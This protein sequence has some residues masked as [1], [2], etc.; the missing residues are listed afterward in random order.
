M[1]LE[2]AELIRDYIK[3][4]FLTLDQIS[5][6]IEGK[7]LTAS[8]QYLSKLQN[9]KT[10]PAS[11]KMNRAI[12]EITGGDPEQ[13]VLA[14]YIDKAPDEIKGKV[15]EIY[16][17]IDTVEETFNDD[18]MDYLIKEVREQ[19]YKP[20]K[21]L[22]IPILGKVAAGKP[23]FAEEN[24]E[25]FVD[26]PNPGEYKSVDLFSLTVKGDS[27]IGSRIND[28]DLAIVKLQ[29][30]VENGEIA[31]VN[32]NGD[33]ITVKKVKKLDNGQ[34]LLMPSNEKYDPII[35]DNDQ[36]RI[37]GKVIQVTFNPNKKG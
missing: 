11:E 32:V 35:V 3:K 20:F 22:R 33:E 27:M 18:N 23:I 17:Q 30:D 19:D 5:E 8:K 13:L 2:Y 31:V 29:P 10:P 21:F 25:G 7:G 16:N 24:I 6:K 1:L 28:G 26:I 4:S 9:G 37:I 14:A 12:A 34:I 36:A 15:K